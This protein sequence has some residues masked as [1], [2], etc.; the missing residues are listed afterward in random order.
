MLHNFLN[1]LKQATAGLSEP[2]PSTSSCLLRLLYSSGRVATGKT[3]GG[4]NLGLYHP[5]NP[6]VRASSGQLQTAL[7][8]YHLTPAQ[9]ILHG[10]QKL[11][12]SGHS[13]SLQL[14]SLGK[15]LL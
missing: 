3:E 10:G 13:Q 6:K 12:V 2:Q 1:P 15:S 14:T 5:G 11:A 7:V 8:H 4:A 9:Q